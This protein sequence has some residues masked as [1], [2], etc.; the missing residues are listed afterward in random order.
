MKLGVHSSL[1]QNCH[2]QII[3]AK[4]NLK[5]CYPPPYES[6]IWHYKHTNVDQIQRPIE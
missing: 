1:H 6:E 4:F 5:V 3:H 2:H